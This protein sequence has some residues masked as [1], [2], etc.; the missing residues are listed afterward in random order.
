MGGYSNSQFGNVRFSSIDKFEGMM[1]D[2][3]LWAGKSNIAF[4]E[5]DTQCKAEDKHWIGI[6]TWRECLG[7]C[8]DNENCSG[9]TIISKKKNPTK[10]VFT[11]IPAF[12][13]VVEKGLNA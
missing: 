2:F 9:I 5:D 4:C 6:R 11:I 10:N 7:D 3:Q 12:D 8:L 1:D 13:F